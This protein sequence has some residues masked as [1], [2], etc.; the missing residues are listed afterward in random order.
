MF[1]KLSRKETEAKGP[2]S[3]KAL[4]PLKLSKTKPKPN[5]PFRACRG[6]LEQVRFSVL[7]E[8]VGAVARVPQPVGVMLDVNPEMHRTGMPLEL[9]EQGG[10]SRAGGAG[11]AGGP[12]DIPP[13]PARTGF[14]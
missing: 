3:L 9:A 6:D 14:D 11:G 13:R 8:D 1:C 10:A 4:I 12:A 7:V 2:Y 5:Q